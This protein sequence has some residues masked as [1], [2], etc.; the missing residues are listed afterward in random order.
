MITSNRKEVISC[1]I[2]VVVLV[3][4]VVAIVVGV[5]FELCGSDI[6]YDYE[7]SIAVS[8]RWNGV[9]VWSLYAL[10]GQCK[11]DLDASVDAGV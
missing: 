11:K 7:V 2:V 1:V 9:P 3:F 10:S 8:S 4:V 5:G 6:V